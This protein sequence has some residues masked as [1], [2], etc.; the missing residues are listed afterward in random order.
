MLSRHCTF[1]HSALPPA[2]LKTQW[3]ENAC[4]KEI[5]E[6]KSKFQCQMKSS[7]HK[8]LDL[9]LVLLSLSFAEG[10]V[11]KEPTNYKNFDI[12]KLQ[13]VS[14]PRL[15]NL[16][17]L[18]YARFQFE[19][20]KKIQHAPQHLSDN[21][22]W[23]QLPCIQIKLLEN[24]SHLPQEKIVPFQSHA[25]KTENL[26]AFQKL[27]KKISSFFRL[28]QAPKLLMSRGFHLVLVS[29]CQES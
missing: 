6:Q 14:E 19:K 28:S 17:N 29:F 7:L 5:I 2:K 21:I 27:L 26:R 12:F 23:R 24:P 20:K 22:V 4:L 9:L 8:R 16:N 25:G 3:S 18:H 15:L 13:P 10:N 1:N 11:E